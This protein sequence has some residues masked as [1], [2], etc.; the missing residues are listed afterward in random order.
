MDDGSIIYRIP[1]PQPTSKCDCNSSGLCFYCKPSHHFKENCSTPASIFCENPI[2]TSA[3]GMVYCLKWEMYYAFQ[4]SSNIPV[5]IINTSSRNGNNIPSASRPI[6]AASKAFIQSLTQAAIRGLKENRSVRINCIAP[7]PIL[8]PLEIGLFVNSDDVFRDL[9]STE[10]KQFDSQG[11]I[12]VPL[13][14]T[15]TTKEIAPTILFLSDYS[16]SSYI[17]GAVIPIDGGYTA[18]PV[19]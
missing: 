8:I 4:Q 18:S 1:P 6:Y 16:Q 17:T 12:G 13:G 2:A 5:S 3:I 15:G 9:S 19:L 10:L 7:G 14:R 11:K